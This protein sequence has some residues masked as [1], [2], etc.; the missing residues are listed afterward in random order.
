MH[1]FESDDEDWA[2]TEAYLYRWFSDDPD[3]P[4]THDSVSADDGAGAAW[5]D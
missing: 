5:E 1:D 2:S 3:S 4:A